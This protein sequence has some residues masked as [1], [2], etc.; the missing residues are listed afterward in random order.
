MNFSWKSRKLGLAFVVILF[1][2]AFFVRTA[3][4]SHDLHFGAIYHPDTPKQVRAVQQF[5]RGEYLVRHD[6]PDYD[7]YPLFNSHLVALWVRGALAV[8]TGIQHHVGSWTEPIDPPT[9]HQLYWITRTW[10]AFLSALAVVLVLLIGRRFGLVVGWGA[11][12]LLLV[13]P[14]DITGAHYASNDTTAA[15]FALAA[16]WFGFRIAEQG[17]WRDLIGGAFCVGAAFSS[18]YHAGMSVLPIV[19]GYWL[20]NRNHFPFWSLQSIGRWAALLLFGLLSVVLTSPQL[21]IYPSAAFKDIL[22]FFAHTADFGLP[23]EFR[24]LPLPLRVYE[25]WKLNIPI[26]INVVSIP[27]AA[28]FVLLIA[29]VRRDPRY[30][31]LLGVPVLHVVA[32]LAGKPNLHTVHHLPALPYI[33]LAAAVFFVNAIPLANRRWRYAAGAVALCWALWQL[34]PMAHREA[35]FFRLNDTRW[36]ARAWALE[37]T[38]AGAHW[39]LGRH[40]FRPVTQHDPATPF[41]FAVR[42]GTLGAQLRDHV[43]IFTLSLE[44]Q[45]LTLFRN[46]D[47]HLWTPAPGTVHPPV[48]LPWHAPIPSALPMNLA[49]LDLPWIGRQLTAHAVQPK[50]PVRQ[51]VMATQQLDRVWLAV[52]TG[53]KPARFRA[54]FGGRSVTRQLRAGQ[55]EIIE[56]TAPRRTGPRAGDRHFYRFGAKAH[57]GE[58]HLHLITDPAVAGLWALQWNDHDTAARLLVDEAERHVIYQAALAIAQS[59]PSESIRTES[60]NQLQQML[61]TPDRW[62][63]KLGITEAWLDALPY[64]TWDDDDWRPTDNGAWLSPDLNLAPGF[65]SVEAGADN[66]AAW[67]LINMCGKVAQKLTYDHDHRVA[68]LRIPP[69]PETWRLQYTGDTVPQHVTIRPDT[70]ATLRDW[71]ERLESEPSEPMAPSDDPSDD[72]PPIARFAN[73]V[74]LQRIDFEI[75]QDGSGHHDRCALRIHWTLPDAFTDP[76][77][78]AVW[79]HINDPDGD[80]VIQGDHSFRD[81]LSRTHSDGAPQPCW[82]TIDLPA[83]LEPGT[84]TIRGGLYRPAHRRRINI[85]EATIPHGRRHLVLGTLQVKADAPPVV[86]VGGF[87]QD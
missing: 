77:Q 42:S 73:G 43:K 48:V 41:A 55:Q 18:K 67:R 78:Y 20:Y 22:A 72:A 12:T 11:A 6:H 65:Y 68:L 51:V 46:R 40:T 31:L 28:G 35:Y 29:R 32:G 7:G 2:A 63:E 87:D 19:T 79:I 15:F 3:G 4:M 61:D 60:V 8:R 85:Q 47:I 74:A 17:R 21:L 27:V 62:T 14:L 30:W 53:S 16:L 36:V 75:Q 66:S 86:Q 71:I 45:P 69:Y 80:T 5:L 13:S 38:P 25:G 37:T 1:I 24:E 54:R 84:Y 52:H 57:W 83:G 9:L 49:P 81:A 44:D 59:T 64:L 10:N 34:V 39:H 76:Q 23:S 70:A 56:L 26:L 33:F 50:Q 58:T 82:H